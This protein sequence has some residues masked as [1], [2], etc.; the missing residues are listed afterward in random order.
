MPS[1]MLG[2]SGAGSRSLMARLRLLHLADPSHTDFL[3]ALLPFRRSYGLYLSWFPLVMLPPFLG[4][5]PCV[6]V[7]GLF[8]SLLIVLPILFDVYPCFKS[9]LLRSIHSRPPFLPY[10]C[11]YA[12]SQCFM[13]SVV[14]RLILGEQG[15]NSFGF[16]EGG[17]GVASIR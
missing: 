4:S 9:L 7:G 1:G 3:F 5:R 14:A 6:H 12:L 15:S 10:L 11:A 13:A 16:V 17:V 2:S 8:G